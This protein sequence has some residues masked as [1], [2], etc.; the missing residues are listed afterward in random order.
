MLL[1][2]ESANCTGVM[3]D[4][5]VLIYLLATVCSLPNYTLASYV[6]HT[7]TSLMDE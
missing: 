5:Q 6:I 4:T 1:I 7:D 2:S 3:T